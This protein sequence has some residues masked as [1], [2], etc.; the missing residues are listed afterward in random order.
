MEQVI[1]YKKNEIKKHVAAIHCSS[2]L[3]L[4]QRKISNALLYHAYHELLRREEH[5][6]TIKQLCNIIGYSGN[7]HSVI[8]EALK[9]LISVVIEWNVVDDKTGEED[10][11][12]SAILACARIKGSKC[13]Y[14]YSP[15]MKNLLYSPSMYG[16][17]NL[18]VQAR[19]K[20]SYGLALYEN[21]VRFKGLPVT[22]WLDLSMFRRLMGVPDNKY[23]I[24]RD[25]KKRVLDK[26]VEEVNSYSDLMV[27]PEINK[28]GRNIVGI[29]FQL[30]D[31]ERKK[32]FGTDLLEEE[33]G[34]GKDFSNG[35][36]VLIQILKE[37]YGLS[38]IQIN[39]ITQ[40]YPEA[41]ILE[42]IKMIESSSSFAAGKIA[43]LSAYLF[44]A[45]KENYQAPKSASNIIAVERKKNEIYEYKKNQD[46]DE[47]D[48]HQQQYSEYA[49]TELDKAL[50][51]LPKERLDELKNN[52]LSTEK[53]QGNIV[54]QKMFLKNGFESRLVK[55]NFHHFVREY[56]V[57]LVPEIMSLDE[58]V[59]K[60]KRITCNETTE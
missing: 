36:N 41:A 45:L 9:G 4:L 26:S 7:N 25:F 55:I 1:K 10:W 50:A 27:T 44:S 17:I 19:F 22:K 37:R 11:S 33:R 58:F 56:Y 13:T 39:T 32:R 60:A 8:K 34:E 53:N 40:A 46:Q 49:V 29:R 47:E 15:R 5:E 28:V 52:F 57:E 24:F 2:T 59:N 43:N 3:S 23:P 6:V 16:K 42:K 54:F 18:I 31:R 38:T 21:C 48:L 51:A 14:A 20:S 12:A 35:E 30:K